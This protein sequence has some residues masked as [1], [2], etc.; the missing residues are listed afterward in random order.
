[1]SGL[2]EPIGLYVGVTGHRDI[3]LGC[4]SAVASV[5][6]GVFAELRERYPSCAVTVLSPLADGADR[7]CAEA[8]VDAGCRLVVPL[9]MDADEYKNDFDEASKREFDELCAKA[10]RVFTVPPPQTASAERGEYYRE[11]GRYVAEHSHIL[12]ALWDGRETLFP[13]GGGTFETI[14]FARERERMVCVIDT[15]RQGGEFRETMPIAPLDERIAVI[16]E[17]CGDVAKCGQAMEKMTAANR[18]SFLDAEAEKALTPGAR[19]VMNAFLC[20]DALAVKN[21]DY[22]LLSLR[23]LSLFGLM[24]VLAFLL[25]DELE[26]NLML[27]VYAGLILASFAVY[28]ISRKKRFHRRY[29]TMRAV[30]EALRIQFYWGLCGISDSVFDSYTFTQK[31]EL[32][33][34]EMILLSLQEELERFD[35]VMPER[36]R[37]LWIHGQLDYHISSETSKSKKETRNK[38]A[39][40]T[41]LVLS[42][43]LFVLVALMELFFK[44]TLETALPMQAVRGFMLMHDG[45]IIWRGILKIILGTI[46]AGTAFLANYYGSLALPR[47]IFDDRRMRALFEQAERA[48]QSDEARFAEAMRMAGREALIESA[49][50]YVSQ[51]ENGLGIFI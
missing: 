2:L 13:E 16:N 7:L 43:A 32:G 12:I 46:S 4:V 25:Y 30:A 31:E 20:A 23:L 39:A 18:E 26:S 49:G 14:K 29:I 48:E 17:L 6:A 5:V 24:M 45:E 21:R 37:S 11:V 36:V 38:K 3:P 47:Q 33:F 27:F 10:D 1:M 34:V 41:M 50:W 40:R 35:T 9:P 19:R 44:D 15:P 51:R 8:A 28:L 42:V 22:K